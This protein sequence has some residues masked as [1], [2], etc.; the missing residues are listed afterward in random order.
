MGKPVVVT[1]QAREGIDA[2]PDVHLC[3]AETPREWVQAVSHLLAH[4]ELRRRLG[5]AARE[6]V[7]QRFQWHVQLQLLI[8]VP[9]LSQCFRDGGAKVVEQA[10][11]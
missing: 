9:G 4:P 6:F 2:T 3:Q 11:V 1:P 10:C 7:E 5:R 8:T